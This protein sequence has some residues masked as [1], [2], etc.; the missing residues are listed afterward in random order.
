MNQINSRPEPTHHNIRNYSLLG[1]CTRYFRD[2]E[3]PKSSRRAIISYHNQMT[4]L[5]HSHGERL[6]DVTGTRIYFGT[7]LPDH[8]TICS[9]KGNGK[10]ILSG[11]HNIQVT[12]AVQIRERW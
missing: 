12:V 2:F 11:K 4:V 3:C 8:R 9:R 1:I 10:S 5:S 6:R 7:T